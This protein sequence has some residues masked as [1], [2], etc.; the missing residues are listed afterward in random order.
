MKIILS[1][2]LTNRTKE[3]IINSLYEITPRLPIFINYMK[4]IS[5]ILLNG[6]DNQEKNAF[7]NGLIMGTQKSEP[8][9]V[10]VKVIGDDIF[11]VDKNTEQKVSKLI[12]E[13]FNKNFLF[14]F[15]KSR[16][17]RHNHRDG[18]LNLEIIDNLDLDD[19]KLFESNDKDDKTIYV[20][21]SKNEIESDIIESIK[22]NSLAFDD[23]KLQF[24]S[25]LVE[26]NTQKTTI[27]DV[28]KSKKPSGPPNYIKV[29]LKESEEVSEQ[30]EQ[31][32]AILD[33]AIDGGIFEQI[34]NTETVRGE[35]FE[36]EL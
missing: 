22:L 19:I 28:I 11:T 36:F 17:F 34:Q 13:N 35:R 24:E 23:I 9:T 33:E 15:Y 30:E 21:H 4:P 20:Y 3:D 25:M 6:R 7:P 5:D 29:E 32:T 10:F 14:N 2:E 27:E 1:S 18:L 8:N 26:N 31:A 16:E 12:K